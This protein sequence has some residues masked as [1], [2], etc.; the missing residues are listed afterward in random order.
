[1]VTDKENILDPFADAN[2]AA[3]ATVWWQARRSVADAIRELIQQFSESRTG[4]DHLL[5]LADN[6]QKLSADLSND[7]G[8]MGFSAFVQEGGHGVN[9]QIMNEINPVIGHSNPIAPPLEVWT[10]GD[11]VKSQV[12][13]PLQY[14]GPPNCVHGGF[15]AAVFDQLCGC[16]QMRIKEPGLTGT[17]SVR[18]MLPV[19]L[20][21]AVFTQAYVDRREGRK[22]FV[23]G[24]MFCEGQQVASCEAIFIRWKENAFE[25]LEKK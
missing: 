11:S 8:S 3:P 14:E 24:E 21:K 13:F 17:L 4:E 7:R 2:P 18:Y 23:K 10:D 16:A 19:P 22:I 1:M 6:I 15:I 9:D 25:D 12:N 5:A 20:N